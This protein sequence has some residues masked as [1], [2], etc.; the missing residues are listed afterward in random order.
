MNYDLVANMLL[1]LLV[2]CVMVYL[3]RIGKKCV[4]K[5]FLLE[6]VL[7]AEDK[8]GGGNGDVKYAYVVTQFYDKLP[9]IIRRLYTK[10]EIGDIIDKL[11]IQ[12]KLNLT[13]QQR[14]LE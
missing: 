11:V 14:K 10:A 1:I 13:Y 9:S 12:L 7:K 8:F 4:A 2:I 6:L 5:K 3:F